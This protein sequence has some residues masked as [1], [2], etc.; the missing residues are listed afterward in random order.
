MRYLL[1]TILA[2]F[3]MTS[4]QPKTANTKEEKNEKQTET[5]KVDTKKVN[6][7]KEVTKKTEIKKDTSANTATN[8]KEEEVYKPKPGIIIDE[9]VMA[10]FNGKKILF[11]DIKASFV[12]ELKAAK[13]ETAK[14]EFQKTK[15]LVN[16][17]VIEKLL[18]MEAKKQGFK[19][20]KELLDKVTSKVE[21]PSQKEVD[22]MKKKYAKQFASKKMPEKE[23]NK[24]VND[25]ITNQKKND[26][27]FK[28]LEKIKKDSGFKIT[29]PYPDIPVVKIE[30]TDK[31]AFKGPK[32]AKY[33]IVEFS[34]F[35][36]PYCSRVAP[37]ISGITKDNKDVKVVFKHFP[38]SFHKMAK[39]ASIATHCANEQGKFWELHD[40]IFANQKDLNDANL[41]KWVK[42][43]KLDMKKYKTCST[44]PE[45]MKII[46]ND[47]LL[48]S[49]L[50]VKGTPSIFLNNV[51]INATTKDIM[52][53]AI[54]SERNKVFGALTND[55]IIAKINK[56][57]IK[58]SDF[59]KENKNFEVLNKSEKMKKNYELYAQLLSKELSK[60]ILEEA[61]KEDGLKTVDE[62]IKKIIDAIKEPTQEEL[63][64]LYNKLKPKLQGKT[65][66]EIRPQLVQYSKREKG[67]NAVQLRM[68]KLSDKYKVKVT[69]PLPVLPKFNINTENSPFIGKKDAE[70][71]LVEFSDFQCPYCSKAAA[72]T[73]EIL[74][75]YPNKVKVVFKH[76]PLP[77]HKNARA[78][79]IAAQCSHKQGKFREFYN[80]AFQNQ[81]KLTEENFIAWAKE[82]KLNIDD[83][84]KCLKDSTIETKIDK[85]LQEGQNLG[86]QGTPTLY[87]N[88]VLYNSAHDLKS[89]SEFIK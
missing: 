74:K 20:H 69:M 36:C 43:L 51:Q 13:T 26:V 84:K 15:L 64:A 66:D 23:I 88:G 2:M 89:F 80:K 49:K 34:D 11:K 72:F 35:Q 78:A 44:S 19:N 79:S 40:K 42:E 87:L 28:Y 1:L 33:V 53:E 68:K 39:K 59:L 6:T 85:D 50:G 56:E 7:K 41:E 31:D 83:F 73:E 75:K 62:Y 82:F 81:A 71:T 27:A 25:Y 57:E 24:L 9:T 21:K 22:E 5:Q 60:Q 58:W 61:A 14:Q 37:L 30:V 46:E 32:D 65:F 12:S 18:T 38:L 8:K 47:I 45:T 52:N 76:F 29:L 86:I 70:Y 63:K 67:Q 3:L 10:E 4:C 48:G 54:E 16:K 17:F 77:F 55:T